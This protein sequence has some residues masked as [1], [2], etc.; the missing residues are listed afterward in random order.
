MI[1]ID[2]NCIFLYIS[3]KYDYNNIIITVE[4]AKLLLCNYFYVSSSFDF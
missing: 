3:I 1:E 2:G 4:S